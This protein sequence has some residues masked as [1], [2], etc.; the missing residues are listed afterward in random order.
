[1]ASVVLGRRWSF[2]FE[3]LDCEGKLQLFQND[4]YFLWIWSLDMSGLL[5]IL[6]VH[7]ERSNSLTHRI[8]DLQKDSA[9]SF[10][11]VNASKLSVAVVRTAAHQSLK[12][13]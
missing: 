11:Q 5:C 8:L 3:K 1:M 13:D 6:R 9:R 10:V 2:G 7:A 12:V 4:C